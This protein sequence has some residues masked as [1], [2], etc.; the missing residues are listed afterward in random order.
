MAG[1][2]T[3]FLL[4]NIVSRTLTHCRADRHCSRYSLLTKDYV[5]RQILPPTLATQR[6]LS[7]ACCIDLFS[8]TPP[9]QAAVE[10]YSP[11]PSRRDLTALLH[12]L[13]NSRIYNPLRT[14]FLFRLKRAL[15]VGTLLPFGL[16]QIT[17]LKDHQI[18]DRVQILV[19]RRIAGSISG[20]PLT[21]IFLSAILYAGCTDLQH[22]EGCG[23]TDRPSVAAV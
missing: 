14:I 23:S 18:V 13:M 20:I 2:R 17:R 7:T 8:D 22:F 3:C 6:Q 9:L 4:P 16:Y 1:L 5:L 12:L 10:K 11:P 19:H 21:C 15:S